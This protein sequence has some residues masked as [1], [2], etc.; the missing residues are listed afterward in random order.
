MGKSDEIV[1]DPIK[2]E[3]YRHRLYN[4]LEE[5]RI[6]IR[7]VTGSAMVAEGGET[8]CSFYTSDGEPVQTAAGILL[9]CTGARDFV[10]KAIEWYQDS[11]GIH[12]GDQFLFN[13]PYIGGT[14]LCDQ[15][16]IKPIF[17]EGKRVAWC[18]SFMH[19]PE[20]GAIAPGGQP[21]HATNIWQEGVAIKGLKIVEKGQFRPEVFNTVCGHSR[22]ANLVGLDTKAKIAANNVCSRQ[23][24]KLIENYGRDFVEAANRRMIKDSEKMV[25]AKLASLPDGVWRTRIYGDVDGLV[26]KPFEVVCKMTKKGDEIVFD[27]TGSSPQNAGSLNCT[28]SGAWGS[29]FVV[30]ASQLF[31]D[32]PWN[33]GLVKPVT[34]IA[35]EGSVVNCTYPAAVSCGVMTSGTL[36]TAAAH[37]CIAKMLFS[38]G[39]IE[40]VN[41]V[42]RG[43][44]GPSLSFGGLNQRGERTAGL[45]LE[46]FASGTG[47]TPC[48][49]GVDT[50]G[51]MMNPSSNISDVEIVE[52]NLPFLHL[53]RFQSTDSGGAGRFR[54]GAGLETVYMIYGTEKLEV[55]L[56]GMGQRAPVNRG[57]FGG[58]PSAIREVRGALNSNIRNWWKEGKSATSFDEVGELEGEHL[59]LPVCCPPKLLHEFDILVARRDGGGGY[60]DPLERDPERVAN[61]L[62][63]G[64]VSSSAARRA[65]GV[66]IDDSTGEV[67][68]GETK[69]LR[70]RMREERLM[71]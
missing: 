29:L 43:A 68:P 42:W 14:H 51:E 62:A 45:L 32:G 60:G 66:V 54:G 53:A 22:D 33:G 26:A 65:Y 44:A 71:R 3:I 20:T 23:L 59:M 16:I 57:M 27:F 8:L 9:H 18:G 30:L 2:Y 7:R 35:P 28:L 19:T 69:E 34:L 50:G 46:G 31:W 25:R 15:I 5:G 37:A 61:D 67:N 21:A 1:L 52:S 38:A 47:A 49:D 64:I 39:R 58:Y 40:E 11:P 36:L 13:D 70:R 17:Y 6:T 56:Q 10:L 12:D 4:V 63:A 41:S 55:G 24:L 48:R